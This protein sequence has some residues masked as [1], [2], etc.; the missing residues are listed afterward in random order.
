MGPRGCQLWDHLRVSVFAGRCDCRDSLCC[1][2]RTRR[3]A[4]GYR[5]VS[6]VERREVLRGCVRGESLRAISGDTGMDRKTVRRYVEAA[7]A[8]GVVADGD[9]GQLTD[10]L[11]GVVCVE[12]R[13]DRQRGHG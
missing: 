12:V 11:I 9:E 5:E 7:Q 6:V 3:S 10:G 8:S 13:P 4:M 1:P 2:G